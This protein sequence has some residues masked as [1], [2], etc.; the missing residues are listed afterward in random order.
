[1]CLRKVVEG[2]NTKEMEKGERIKDHPGETG[3]CN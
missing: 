2:S 3:G 1:M